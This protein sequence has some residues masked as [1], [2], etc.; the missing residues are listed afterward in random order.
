MKKITLLFTTLLF[1]TIVTSQ[2]IIK[3]GGFE[4]RTGESWADDWTFE[5]GNDIERRIH[6]KGSNSARL[7]SQNG[8]VFAI[9]QTGYTDPD[10]GMFKRHEVEP[11]AT[12]K[13]TYWVLDNTNR[14]TLKHKVRWLDKDEKYISVNNQDELSNPTESSQDNANWKQIEVTGKAPSNAKYVAIFFYAKSETGGGGKSVYLDEVSFVKD[15]RTASIDKNLLKST[16]CFYNPITKNIHIAVNPSTKIEYINIFNVL[17]KE[18]FTTTN[19]TSQQIIPAPISNGVAIIHLTT[20][21]G[22]LTKKIIIN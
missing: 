9:Y 11:N 20:N 8:F 10:F 17:G 3:N 22:I 1:S 21:K 7:T 19:N 16:I 4:T 18:I 14:A 2:N 6:K 13:L 5:S 12:Y 15:G